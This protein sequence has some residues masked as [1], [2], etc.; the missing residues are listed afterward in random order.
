[1]THFV[2]HSPAMKNYRYRVP[3]TTFWFAHIHPITRKSLCSD[4]S[5]ILLV[6]CQLSPIPYYNLSI[7]VHTP[8]NTTQI[9]ISRSISCSIC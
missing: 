2:K 8:F 5:T 9:Y 3:G 4:L 1:M 6:S 7:T